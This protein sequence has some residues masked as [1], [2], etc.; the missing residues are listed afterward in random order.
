MRKGYSSMIDKYLVTPKLLSETER[1][2]AVVTAIRTAHLEKHDPHMFFCHHHGIPS[3]IN[4]P[5]LIPSRRIIR[6]NF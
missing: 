6:I 3:H 4:D 1:G 2:V 5:S